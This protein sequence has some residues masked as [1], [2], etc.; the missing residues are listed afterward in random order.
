VGRTN[1]RLIVNYEQLLKKLRARYCVQWRTTR[2]EGSFQILGYRVVDTGSGN[3][4][5]LFQHEDETVCE[6]VCDMLNEG[7]NK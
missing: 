1:V 5:T 6:K 2:E 7:D 3:W 4:P